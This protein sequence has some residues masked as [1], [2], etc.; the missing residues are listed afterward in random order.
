MFIIDEQFQ[1]NG[2]QVNTI[3]Y[4]FFWIVAI[5]LQKSNR[6]EI[7]LFRLYIF[8]YLTH[9]ASKNYSRGHESVPEY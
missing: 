7:N 2:M 6:N 5:Q 4:Q 8:S 3:F 9:T 1:L